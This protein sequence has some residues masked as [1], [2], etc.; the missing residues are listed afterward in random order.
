MQKLTL[1]LL[2]CGIFGIGSVAHAQVYKKATC[3]NTETKKHFECYVIVQPSSSATSQAPG[4]SRPVEQTEY[5][6]NQ[7]DSDGYFD[8]QVGS[9]SSY[10]SWRDGPSV[11]VQFGRRWGYSQVQ[12]GVRSTSPYYNGSISP[13]YYPNRR[14]YSPR[15]HYWPRPVSVIPY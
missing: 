10:R 9:P 11:N 12:G 5:W 6:E 4:P 7:K 1:I 14:I 8:V 3:Y 15:Y 13:G 2:V